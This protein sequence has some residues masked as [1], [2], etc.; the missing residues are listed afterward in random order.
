MIKPIKEKIKKKGNLL[1][2]DALITQLP[3][4]YLKD[5]DPS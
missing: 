5:F 3:A 1:Y 4:H 2:F